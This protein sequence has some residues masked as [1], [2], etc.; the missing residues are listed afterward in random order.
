MKEIPLTQGFKTQIDDE[1][2]EW[3]IQFKWFASKERNVYYCNTHERGT[4]RILRMA[5]LIMNAPKGYIVDHIDNNGLNNQRSNLRLCTPIQN[6]RNRRK[7]T[8]KTSKYK[9]VCWDKYKKMWFCCIMLNRKQ[10]RLGYF[11]AEISA[12]LTYDEAAK[13]YHG[14]FANLNFK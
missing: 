10:I 7:S 9:G 3:L 12:A 6:S 11:E 1:D 4:D 2:Y 5:R 8:S 14:E 13:K